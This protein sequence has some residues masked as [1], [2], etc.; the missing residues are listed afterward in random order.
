MLPVIAVA[1]ADIV[2]NTIKSFLPDTSEQKLESIRLAIQQQTLENELLNKQLDIDNT[3]AASS[4]LFKSGWRPAVG[5]MCTFGLGYQTIGL[6]LIQT[7][8]SLAVLWGADVNTIHAAQSVL[9]KMDTATL[10]NLLGSIL[11]IGTIGTL[12]TIEKIKGVS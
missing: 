6:A 12:R 3:E 9:P 7:C 8:F 2:T 1:L 5:W 11:G 10:I 4:S